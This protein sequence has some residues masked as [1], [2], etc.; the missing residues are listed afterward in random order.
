MS[1]KKLNPDDFEQYVVN[2]LVPCVVKFYDKDCYLCR[3]LSTIYSD[4]SDKYGV[5]FN[6]FKI[7]I[8]DDL[9]FS[10]RYL[11]GGVP[12]IIIFINSDVPILIE[13]P[14]QPDEQSGYGRDYLDKWL[15]HFR[16]TIEALRLNGRQ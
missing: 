7:D 8:S 13:Y 2:S 14:N 12:T 9:E 1:V 11:D 15:K 5:D 3:G 4:M 10:E 16:I 6:F